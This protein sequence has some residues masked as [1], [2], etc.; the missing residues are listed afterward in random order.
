MKG[1]LAKKIGMTRVICP[2]TG[3]MIPVT[4]LEAPGTD[5][6]QVKTLESDGY[7]SVVMASFARKSAGKNVGQ[8]YKMIKELRGKASF[9]KGDVVN[10]DV[11]GLGE[12]IKITGRSKGRGFA[13][14]IKRHNFSRGPETHGS[15]H[16]REPGSVGMCAKPGR[17]LKGQKMPGH[18]GDDQVTFITKV[19][20]I[21]TGKNLLA[22]RGGV[23]GANGGYL[24]LK[25]RNQ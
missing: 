7:E 5:I 18:Y 3:R 2:D 22:V 14:V 11:F 16:H 6:L 13:G 9:A 4:V 25:S 10:A 12:E 17:I 24:V 23:P 21:D 1:I 15:H 19:I 8:K 20:K